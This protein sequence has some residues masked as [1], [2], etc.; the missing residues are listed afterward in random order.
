MVKVRR[1]QGTLTPS[2]VLERQ[3]TSN[4]WTC[5][6]T[7]LNASLLICNLGICVYTV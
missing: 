6:L 4:Y 2:M 1:C 3:L 7:S 5:V